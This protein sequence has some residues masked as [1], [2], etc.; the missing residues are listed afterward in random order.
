MKQ[1]QNT[2]KELN[3][4]FIHLHTQNQMK[5]ETLSRITQ[6]AI[7]WLNN[8]LGNNSKQFVIP[9]YNFHLGYLVPKEPHLENQGLFPFLKMPQQD[10]SK[11]MQCQSI[12][13]R[14]NWTKS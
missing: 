2:E 14:A 4:N 12:K 9:K 3:H 1:L 6:N 5:G 8:P 7:K 10:R 11:R 13:Q